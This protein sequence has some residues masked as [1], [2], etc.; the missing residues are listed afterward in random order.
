MIDQRMNT[1]MPKLKLP[2]PVRS[3]V[4]S[5]DQAGAADSAAREASPPLYLLPRQLRQQQQKERPGGGARYA[6]AFSSYISTYR[7]YKLRFKLCAA[8]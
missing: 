6:A 5:L 3:C 2:S 8:S 7:L 1:L 4:F